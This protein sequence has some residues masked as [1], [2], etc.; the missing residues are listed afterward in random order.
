MNSK[1]EPQLILASA[2]PRRSELLTQIGVKHRKLAVDICEDKLP[3][4]TAMQYVERLAREKARAGFKLAGCGRPALGS[5]TSVVID[6]QVLGK[7]VDEQDAVSMLMQLSGRVHQVM[8]AVA[9]CDG[10]R[11]LSQVVTTDVTFVTLT[12]AQCRL[13]WQ[14]SEPCDKAGAYG[15]QGLGAVF[16]ASISGSYSAVVGLP[17][18]ETAR[19]LAEFD[20]P[21]WATV[22]TTH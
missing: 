14:S 6:G 7:P 11:L 19:M 15:I 8:T 4:E 20:V 9:V 17:L 3:D 22:D 18:M 1:T 12:Q 10:D 2:S 13:Y 21:V 5:D 16:V